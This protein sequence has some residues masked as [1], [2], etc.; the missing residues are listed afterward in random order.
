MKFRDFFSFV[1]VTAVLLTFV[2]AAEEEFSEEAQELFDDYF[3]WRMRTNPEFASLRV[4][5][6][7]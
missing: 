7:S 1:V 2:A 4:P 3:S 6:R 5:T